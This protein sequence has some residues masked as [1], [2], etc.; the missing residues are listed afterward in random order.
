MA[1]HPD[2]LLPIEPRTRSIARRLYD[3]V[4]HLP[5]LSP[6]GHTDP[7]WYAED[8][9]FPDPASLFVTPDHYVFRMLH[10]Q[11]VRLEDLGVP[12]RD[13]TAVEANSRKIAAI[14]SP[15]MGQP[16]LQALV[17]SGGFCAPLQPL[18]TMPNL[19]TNARP[20]RD[21]L[22]SFRAER[23]GINVPAPTTV[24]DA[25]R[26]ITVI[27]A[28]EDALD[29]ASYIKPWMTREVWDRHR[30]VSVLPPMR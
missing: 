25:A 30:L 3:E 18:Y 26:A 16:G 13:G 17:A 6:H 28:D 19:A 20:V 11:G 27:T 5:I 2:R 7:R 29:R 23:G 22:P 21:A 14:G 15:Y 12:T 8:D 9:A 1:L 10:S 4:A 24:S